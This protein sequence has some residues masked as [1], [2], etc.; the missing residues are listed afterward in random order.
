MVVIGP[1]GVLIGR[2]AHDGLLLEE[3]EVSRQ[4]ARIAVGPDGSFYLEDLGS[5]NGTFVGEERIDWAPLVSGDCIRLGPRLR[6]RFALTDETEESL[7][8]KL[9]ESSVR[10]SLTQ[11]F[12]RRYLTERL[13]KEVSR[14]RATTADAALL[15]IDVDGLKQ[16]NDR[17]GHLAGDRALC[18]VAARIGALMPAE[19]VLARYG[20]DEF[21]V[22]APGLG[23]TAAT[24]L[25]RRLREG[26]AQNHFSAGG[27]DVAITVSIGIAALSELSEGA[28]AATELFA[29]ADGRLYSAKSS[30]RNRVCASVA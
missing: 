15:V 8:R 12:T 21:V 6:L 11:A 3:T 13:A 18:A 24:L 23:L 26:I 28:S 29:L 25:G 16:L 30:G 17:Y 14:S 27:H 22:L 20:G 5:T 1:E 7:Q 19:N 10:D 9:Y 4:H 2:H